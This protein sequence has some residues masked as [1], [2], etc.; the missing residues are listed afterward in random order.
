[1]AAAE[2]CPEQADRDRDGE[3]R[4]ETNRG[5]QPVYFGFD[6]AFVCGCR[7]MKCVDATVR[8]MLAREAGWSNACT[9]GVIPNNSRIQAACRASTEW[10]PT[11]AASTARE[12]SL[13]ACPL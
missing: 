3:R 2:A 11:A 4:R 5:F 9:A 13:G 7:A 1:M 6:L 10:M 8:L 12:R